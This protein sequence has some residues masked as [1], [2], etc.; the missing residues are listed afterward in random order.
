[1]KKII[2]FGCFIIIQVLVANSQS[3]QK[4]LPVL[5]GSYLGQILQEN[6]LSIFAPY[7]ISTGLEEAVITFMPDGKECYWSILL[8]GF[9]TILTSRFE[10]NKWTEPEVAPFSGKYYDGW[11]AIQPDGKRIF[12]HSTRPIADTSTGITAKFNVWYMDRTESSWSDPVVVN[13]PVNGSENSTCPS[14]TMSGN[15]YI[16]KRFSDGSEKLCRSVLSNG[17]YQELEELP[18]NINVLK[19]NFHGYISPDESYLIRPCY[20]RPD[21]IGAGWNY[22]ISFRKSDGTWSD[23]VNLGKEV[24]SVYCAGAPSISSNSKYLFFQG[25]AATNITTSLDRKY[26]LEE[27]INKEIRNHSNGCADI[28]W[29]NSK[30]IEE[31]RPK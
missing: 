10:N 22:Y 16:S 30:I 18:D 27:L 20:G 29:I 31:L 9:E 11:P 12:F 26:S 15:L 3:K 7:F 8:S 2:F 19:D 13:T 14:V 23:L 21:N 1:M 25:I 5:K 4:E 6:K 28:Y 17:V 24:N